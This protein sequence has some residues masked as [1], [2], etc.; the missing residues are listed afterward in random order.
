MA[1]LEV[2][3]RRASSGSDVDDL[4]T[5]STGLWREDAGTHDPEVMNTDWP[6]QH[7]RASFEALAM[8]RSVD[9]ATRFSDSSEI[10][11]SCTASSASAALRQCRRPAASSR[12][13]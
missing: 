11:A 2:R 9:E 5:I 6:T 8:E 12:W 13:L 3:V 1:D 4:L 7:G 10:S